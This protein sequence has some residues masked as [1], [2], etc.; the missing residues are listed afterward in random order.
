MIMKDRIYE[1]NQQ[2]SILISYMNAFNKQC[3]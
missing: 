2:C 3:I 1:H